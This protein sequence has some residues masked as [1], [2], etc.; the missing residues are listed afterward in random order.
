[1]ISVIGF[2]DVNCRLKTAY[3]SS[4]CPCVVANFYAYRVPRMQMEGGE[5]LPDHSEGSARYKLLRLSVMFA[6]S[7]I[8][9]DW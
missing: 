3:P 7:E 9:R 4:S 6:T 8:T 1:M 5:S 2:E